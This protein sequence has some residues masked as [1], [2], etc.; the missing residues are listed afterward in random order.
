[1]SNEFFEDIEVEVI[2]LTM[3]DG[4]EQEFIIID[5]FELDGKNYIVLSTIDEEDN[6]GSDEYIY[7][8]TEEGDDLII[9]YI[10]DDDEYDRICAAYA[11]LC[12]EEDDLD[13]E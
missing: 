7:G 6:I 12:E 10:D 3:E 11:A 4:K 5:E 8:C 9:D 1:M 2:T 13:A